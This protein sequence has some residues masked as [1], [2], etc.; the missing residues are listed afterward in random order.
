MT[1]VLALSG[2]IR[3]GVAAMALLGSSVLVKLRFE[4]AVGDSLRQRPVKTGRFETLDRLA[5]RRRRQP[6]APSDLVLGNPGEPQTQNL[7]HAAHGH[8]PCW[9]QSAPQ[10]KPKKR[11]LRTASRGS[12]YSSPPGDIIPEWGRGLIGTPGG[13]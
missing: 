8:S 5:H 10:P 4:I 2:T 7:A 3:V 6:R 11:T 12:R 9:H 13:D 1:A